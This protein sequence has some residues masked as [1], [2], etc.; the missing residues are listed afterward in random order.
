MAL[1]EGASHTCLRFWPA[2]LTA[3]SVNKLTVLYIVL[4]VLV[5]FVREREPLTQ[6]KQRTQTR[7]RGQ[8]IASDSNAQELAPSADS[9]SDT[10]EVRAQY[11]ARV[12]DAV[13]DWSTIYVHPNQRV[14]RF[15]GPPENS[16]QQPRV[17]K[18]NV[19]Y[20]EFISPKWANA[21]AK[22]LQ[23]YEKA[24]S[25]PSTFTVFDLDNLDDLIPKDDLGW[26]ADQEDE[27]CDPNGV[28]ADDGEAL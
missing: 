7:V 11:R 22:N 17:H 4:A 28:G 18:K 19:I 20:K 13:K 21:S 6:H 14:E 2:L 24:P 9:E 23:F 1:S 10:E 3:K 26:L 25:C 16:P 12:G 5:R 15:R 27:G 8:R